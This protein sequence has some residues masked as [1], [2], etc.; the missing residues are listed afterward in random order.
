M[1]NGKGP[2]ETEADAG[3]HDMEEEDI[4]DEGDPIVSL[5]LSK[6]HTTSKSTLFKAM[7]SLGSLYDVYFKSFVEGPEFGVGEDFSGKVAFVLANVRTTQEGINWIVM[8]SIVCLSQTMWR[9]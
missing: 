7:T 4:V 2:L 6:E 1:E 8:Q 5:T 3:A 9:A